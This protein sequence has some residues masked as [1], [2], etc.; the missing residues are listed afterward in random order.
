M[1]EGPTWRD[2]VENRLGALTSG[3]RSHE[4][5]LTELRHDVDAQAAKID[6]LGVTLTNRIDAAFGGLRADSKSDIGDLGKEMRKEL[7]ELQAA[8]T[9]KGGAGPLNIDWKILFVVG[10]I[11]A[12]GLYGAGYMHGG[13]NPDL[14]EQIQK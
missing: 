8:L 11:L 1:S 7:H 2:S 13:G 12:G 3:Q 14:M 6:S 5:G 10:V 9:S 4:T